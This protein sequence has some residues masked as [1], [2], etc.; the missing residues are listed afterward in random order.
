MT[1]R[2]NAEAIAPPQNGSNPRRH[3]RA[4][5]SWTQNANEREGLERVEHRYA[6]LNPSKHLSTPLPTLVDI[7]SVSSSLGISTRQIRRF[8]AEGQIPFVRVGHLIR[9]DPGELNQ[10]IDARRAGSVQSR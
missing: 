7:Q 4:S 2:P 8:I 5:G 3:A 6:R 10:W 1:V 9:F